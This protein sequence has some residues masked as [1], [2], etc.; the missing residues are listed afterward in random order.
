MN[1]KR[2]DRGRCFLPITISEVTGLATKF[3]FRIRKASTIVLHVEHRRLFASDSPMPLHE[4]SGKSNNNGI[5]HSGLSLGYLI[6]IQLMNCTRTFTL[7][8]IRPLQLSHNHCPSSHRCV[9]SLLAILRSFRVCAP[10]S[11]QHTCPELGTF[12]TRHNDHHMHELTRNANSPSFARYKWQSRVSEIWIGLETMTIALSSRRVYSA[13]QL[14]RLR[15]TQSQPKLHEAIEEHG[16]EDAE[17]VKGT[18]SSL[19]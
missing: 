15:G 11:F 4:S 3:E 5:D 8:S 18:D 17:I 1:G 7:I 16:R 14:H 6:L 19:L 13:E 2:Q 12:Q 10:Q 9:H